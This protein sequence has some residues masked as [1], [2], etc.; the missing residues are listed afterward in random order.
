MIELHSKVMQGRKEFVPTNYIV[1]MGLDA[2]IRWGDLSSTYGQITV[3]VISSQLP[4][5]SVV[6]DLPSVLFHYL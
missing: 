4:L 2:R 5:F 3:V 6:L 1:D